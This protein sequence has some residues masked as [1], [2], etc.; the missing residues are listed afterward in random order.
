MKTITIVSPAYNEEGNVR[1][2][3]QAVRALFDGPLR[4]YAREHIF[5]DNASL[6][7]TPDLLREIAATDPAVKVVLNARNFGP[8]RSMFNAL[9]Y[10]TGDAVV[11]FL[12]TDLQDP[13]EVIVEMVQLWETGVEVVAGART[14]RQETLA[15]RTA[16]GIFYRLVNALS[17]IDIPI[18]V[19][20]FQLIDRK[21]W[22]ALMQFRDHYPYV[23]GLIASLGFRRVIVPYTWQARRAGVSANNLPRLMDQ[24]LN[25]IFSF[26]NVPMRVCSLLGFVL[27]ALC[28]LYSLVATAAWFVAP[29]LVPRGIT[30]VIVSIFLLSGVQ[31]AFIGM[32]GEYVTSIHAQVRGGPLVIERERLNI[33]DD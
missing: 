19:G 18:N 3:H 30:T 25:G 14:N 33:A 23:R 24:A 1:T 5:A 15:L 13:P 2:C 17:N 11:V 9:R 22:R 4:G 20:E 8:F 7:A 28:V 32:L 26:T 6:D 27:A 10:A 21:V 16:R 31:L 29:H 12:A